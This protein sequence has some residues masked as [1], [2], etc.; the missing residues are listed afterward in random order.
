MEI[1]EAALKEELGMTHEEFEGAY[2]VWRAGADVGSLAET[3]E[4]SVAVLSWFLIMRG[5]GEHER[6]PHWPGVL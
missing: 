4:C 3:F 1:A 6:P 2:V 5:A